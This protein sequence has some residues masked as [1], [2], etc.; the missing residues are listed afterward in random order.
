MD[1]RMEGWMDGWIDGWKDGWMDVTMYASTDLSLRDR[2]GS[3]HNPAKG[4]C[5]F[6][7]KMV[8]LKSSSREPQELSITL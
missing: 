3:C 6:G 1:G 5:E 4:E 2:P 7:N 8:R